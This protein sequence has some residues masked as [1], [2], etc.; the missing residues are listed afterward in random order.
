MSTEVATPPVLQEQDSGVL[1]LTL[2]RPGVLNAINDGMLD[3]LATALRDAVSDDGVR[4]VV[5][6]GA[7]RAFCSGQDLRSAAS[8]GELNVRRHLRE[9]YVPAIHAIRDL[10]KPVIGAVNGVAAGAGFSLA[11]ACDLRVASKSASFLQAFVRIGLIPDASS[12]YFLP[13][14]IGPARAAEL[15]MLGESVEAKR[16]LE[17]GLVNRVVADEALLKEARALAA[18]LAQ[19]PRS[20]GFIK[21]ALNRSLNNDLDAQLLVEEEL[22]DAAT[23]TADFFEG[24]SAFLEKRPARFSG[25]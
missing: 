16:A 2:N 9:H 22:Q 23:G 1:T 10:E 13:R 7:G 19:G 24:V 15:M 12:T 20:I 6:T 5:I 25:R 17:I 4:A 14:L 3:A 21:H 11:L 8:D 18:R